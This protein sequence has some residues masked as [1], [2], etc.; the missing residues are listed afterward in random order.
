MLHERRNQR[1]AKTSEANAFVSLAYFG[2]LVTKI[3]NRA[4]T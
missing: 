1:S 2:S 4:M 3:K